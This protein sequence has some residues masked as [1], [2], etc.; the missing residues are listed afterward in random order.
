MKI[1]GSYALY[2]IV[3][4]TNNSYFILSLKEWT[5]NM[6]DDKIQTCFEKKN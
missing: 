5:Q 3:E 2:V 4:L 1:S 6:Q